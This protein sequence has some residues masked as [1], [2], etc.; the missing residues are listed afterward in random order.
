M[1]RKERRMS[2]DELAAKC[3]YASKSMISRIE[4]GEIDLTQSKIIA[5][6]NA[7]D[8]SP[9]YLM[10]WTENPNK[11]SD[12]NSNKSDDGFLSFSNSGF[13]SVQDAIRFVLEQPLVAD[14][15]GYDLSEM[16]DDDIIAFA[17]EIAGMIQYMARHRPKPS[18]KE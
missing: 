15:G 17:N 13:S 5:I 7:L 9:E 2:Q 6:A 14:Y 11:T 12:K 10:G 16:S 3:G 1:L 18:R 8:T 4:K